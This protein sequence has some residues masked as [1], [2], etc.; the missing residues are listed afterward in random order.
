MT[1]SFDDNPATC[2]DESSISPGPRSRAI[3]AGKLIDVSDVARLETFQWPVAVTRA[4]W[5]ECVAYLGE[6]TEP[7]ETELGRLRDLL[8]NCA[9]AVSR[10]ERQTDRTC[11]TH[12]RVPPDSTNDQKE[13]VRLHALAHYGDN[14][15]AVVT[16]S[17]VT[18][19]G[20]I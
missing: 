12:E 5:D 14:H 7:D 17:L 18:A 16:I 11:F 19:N 20:V 2:N 1:D 8:L 4:V 10:A 6:E 3:A 9:I 15:E 13:P